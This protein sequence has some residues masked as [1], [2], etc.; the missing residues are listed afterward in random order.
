[1]E[2]YKINAR[3]YELNVVFVGGK[4]V[5]FNA[6]CG[7]AAIAERTTPYEKIASGEESFNIKYGNDNLVGGSMG[8]R[9]IIPVVK[10]L[11]NKA[12]SR[13]IQTKV[14]YT[15]ERVA[16]DKYTADMRLQV[17]NEETHKWEDE[18]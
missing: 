8:Y 11:V 3:G 17:Y 14:T 18:Q 16:L 2:F 9:G 6:W 10:R 5:F 1:M 15:E 4:Y 12:E 13:Y 7:I